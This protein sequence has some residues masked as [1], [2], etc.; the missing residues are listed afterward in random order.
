[1]VAKAEHLR[2]ATAE[3]DWSLLSG[4]DHQSIKCF[5]QFLHTS[6]LDSLQNVETYQLSGG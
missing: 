4:I 5:S 3:G 6:E 2:G 1:M